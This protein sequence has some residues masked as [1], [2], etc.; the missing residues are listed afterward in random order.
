MF[1]SKTI[2]IQG[3]SESGSVAHNPKK[4]TKV[5]IMYVIIMFYNKTTI[6]IIEL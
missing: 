1:H 4:I 5:S 3:N 2:I 6:M